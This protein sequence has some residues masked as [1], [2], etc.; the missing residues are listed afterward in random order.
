VKKYGDPS[1]VGKDDTSIWAA[2]KFSSVDAPAEKLDS[3]L[4]CIGTNDFP[5]G[6]NDHTAGKA[7]RSAAI[8]GLY[9]EFT[10][11]GDQT[12]LANELDLGMMNHLDL[13]RDFETD[14]QDARKRIDAAKAKNVGNAAPA[15]Q[16]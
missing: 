6:L 14:N 4:D 13:V 15:P 12:G 16:L 11:R 10:V 2:W 3:R 9:I 1:Y 8:C 5:V 7:K